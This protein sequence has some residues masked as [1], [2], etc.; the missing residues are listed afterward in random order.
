MD[1]GVMV[2]RADGRRKHIST[3]AISRRSTIFGAVAAGI[4]PFAGARAQGSYPSRAVRLIVPFGPGGATDIT[5]RIVAEKLGERYGQRFVVENQPGAGGIAAAR[6]V[7]SA[8]TDGHTIGVAT[9]GT[10]T[11]VSLFKALPFDPLKDF[12]MVSTLGLFEAV[13]AVNAESPY[14][15]L[16]DF[17]K[18]AKAEPGKLNVGTVAVGG[19]QFLAAELFKIDAG[20]DFQIVTFRTSPEIVVA[21]LRNDIHM[22]IEF[23]TAVR[24]PLAEK[25]FHPLATS[26]LARSNT[27]PDV[28]TVNESGVRGYEVTS[29]NALFVANG[30]APE[31]INSLNQNVHQ[32]LAMP[33]VR[34]RF[35]EV[36]IE[37]TASTPEE[38]TNRLRRDIDKWAKVI[39]R[40]KIPKQ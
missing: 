34:R 35:A 15:T 33:D 7:L 13:F 4:M 19:S 28:P 14:K 6:S 1:M 37:A 2:M 21:L 3:S 27:L 39:E 32:V 24:A 26:S 38:L 12:Q 16:Q 23:Y 20:I 11:S 5:T 29:W 8:G 22:T 36:G 40:A 17:I 31:V 18:A 25:K 9:N 10:A 30:T